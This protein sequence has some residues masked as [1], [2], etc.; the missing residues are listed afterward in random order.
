MPKVLPKSGVYLI[1]N[2]V[3]EKVYV[4]SSAKSVKGRIAGHRKEL[5]NGYHGNR[6]L[7]AAWNKYGEASFEFKSICRC[8]PEECIEIEQAW[9]DAYRS[10]ERDFGYNLSPTAGSCLGVKHTEEYC[11]R[12]GD[13]FRGKKC[14]RDLVERRAA[15]LR[16]RKQKPETVARRTATLNTP[17]VRAK[18]SR[19][20]KSPGIQERLQE[21]RKRLRHTPEAKAKMSADRKGRRVSEQTRQRMVEAAKLRWQTNP[22][23]KE[24]DK[25][26][27]EKL[28]GRKIPRDVVDKVAVALR[29]RKRSLDAIEKT[30]NKH[31]G[32]KRSVE[33]CIKIALARAAYFNRKREL[34][35]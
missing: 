33:T 29:G 34:V 8:E 22:R 1:R 26:V 6:H 19:G 21:S 23:S 3:N 11:K 15:K 28:K 30:A 16:G 31:R 25:R 14:P 27:S 24:A 5:R 18:I 32:M 13:R 17:E 2:K 7:Q 9:I 20:V 12:N 35:A 4:G 10:A